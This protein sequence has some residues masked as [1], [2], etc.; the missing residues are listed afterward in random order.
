MFTGIITE[1]GRVEEA[2]AEAG[3]R[4]L[5]IRAAET[6]G[7]LEP[8]G[9]VSVNGCCLTAEE[10]RDELSNQICAAVQWARCV[11]A[12][13]N[14]G[15]SPFVEVG[16]GQ[17]LSKLVR[18]IRGDAQ[19]FG[20]EDASTSDLLNLVATIPVSAPVGAA[21]HGRILARPDEVAR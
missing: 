18:R 7:G 2:R 4:R 19:V 16:P 1:V 15:A 8:A 3:G 21:G 13:A 20:A 5:R 14:Q 9:S 6:A 10:V 12:M 17:A 11:V